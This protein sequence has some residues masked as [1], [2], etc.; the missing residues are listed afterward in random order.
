MCCCIALFSLFVPF[1][2]CLADPPPPAPPPPAPPAVPPPAVA[3]TTTTP[4]CSSTNPTPSR[5]EVEDLQKPS[6]MSEEVVY[7]LVSSPSVAA[8]ALVLAGT[9]GDSAADDSV[10]PGTDHNTGAEAASSTSTTNVISDVDT[11]DAIMDDEGG[12]LKRA[13]DETS[14]DSFDSD[15][16][17]DE[18]SSM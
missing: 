17:D 16:N 1:R 9:A 6:R 11:T 7:V 10:I 12:H 4:I 3:P 14:I 2:H 8:S 13:H 18:T 15:W 5:Q